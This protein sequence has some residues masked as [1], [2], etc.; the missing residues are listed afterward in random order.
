MKST[1]GQEVRL[2]TLNGF[3]YSLVHKVLGNEVIKLFPS[4]SK[5]FTV[6][7]VLDSLLSRAKELR[8][9]KEGMEEQR[10]LLF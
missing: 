2:K 6:G 9:R 5:A 1:L 8:V 10:S 4:E 7:I 3:K